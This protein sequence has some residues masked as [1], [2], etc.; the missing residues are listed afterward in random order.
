MKLF[1]AH[2]KRCAPL[3][4]AIRETCSSGLGYIHRVKR[5]WNENRSELG[6]TAFESRSIRSAA[7]SAILLLFR[8]ICPSG[9][10]PTGTLCFIAE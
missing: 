4:R 6:L 1:G 5:L 8:L 2:T 3:N 9:L 10:R 7:E